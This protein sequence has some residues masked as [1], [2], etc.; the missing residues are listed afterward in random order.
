[1]GNKKGV[2]NS[3]FTKRKTSSSVNNN[4]LNFKEKKDYKTFHNSENYNFKK[5]SALLFVIGVGVF[6]FY[7]LLPYV[8]AFFGAF[9][10]FI[11]FKPVYKFLINRWGW[12]K[13][14]AAMGVIILSI[15]IIVVPIVFIINATYGEI[16]FLYQN[17]TEFVNQANSISRLI[18]GVN[19]GQAV[20]SQLSQIS[21]L[22]TTMLFNSI[23]GFS[24]LMI[25]MT[26]MYFILFF[27]LIHSGNV[28]NK[29]EE[30]IPFNKS[31]SEK[32][33]AELDSITFATIISTGLI[34]LMQG[35]LLGLGFMFFGIRGAF[36]WGF[37][38]AILAFLPV[39]G[40]SF[41]GFPSA[42]LYLLQGNYYVGIGMIIWTL[43]I[44][45]VDNFIR[46]YLQNQFGKIHPLISI[47]GIFIG[48][49]F[50]GL[51]GIVVGPLLL[52]YFLS[53]TK[54][55]KEEYID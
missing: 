30:L 50:F 44:A 29:F 4:D 11:L 13:N 10:M 55:F 36:M 32:L 48:I 39:V 54:M 40:V 18:P 37:I 6:L 35:V 8:D 31:N 42:A 2:G 28:K 15:V 47:I 53:T 7:A 20:Q 45:N 14:I 25:S 22:I 27:L 43:F 51:F 16:Y 1:M 26:I 21:S 41:I 46:P 19:L 33:L 24:R 52:S 23:Q 38:G 12:K 17:Q 5:Y 3:S 34:A 9:I 49:P